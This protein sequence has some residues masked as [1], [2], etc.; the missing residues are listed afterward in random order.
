MQDIKN[1]INPKVKVPISR[2]FPNM[3]T[4]MAICFGLTSIRYAL[5][6][7]W[8]IATAFIIISGFLDVVDGRLARFLKATSDFGAQL[9]SL[10]DFVNFGVAPAVILYLWGLNQISIKGLGWGLVLFYTICSAIRLAR[11]NS[12][13]AN[14]NKPAWKDGFFTGVPA[15]AGAYLAM[16]PIMLSF[17]FNVLEYVHP[18]IIGIYLALIGLLMASRLPTFATKKLVIKKEH[19]SFV[20]VLAGLLIGAILIEPWIALPLFGLVYLFSFPFSIALHS[21]MKNN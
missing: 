10:A 15:P 1:D 2:L 18:I 19:I 8:D 21:R 13:L 5:K 4:I 6:G 12:E 20:L 14:P 9:D 3:I 11:F 17:N 7:N 16:I